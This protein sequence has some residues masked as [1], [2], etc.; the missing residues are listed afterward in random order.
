MEYMFTPWRRKYVVDGVAEEGCVFCRLA[1]DESARDRLL[2]TEHWYLCLNAYPYC[3]GHLMLVSKNHLRWLSEL[4]SAALA[5]MAPLL[6]RAEAALRQAY[7]PE[8]MNM[9]INFA[10]AGGAGVPG[11]LHIHLLPRWAGD[12][13]FMTSVAQTRILPESLEQS[14]DRIEKALAG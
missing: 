6:A 4:S 10:D 8:G 12:T 11:H 2:E 1:A 13:N 7:D 14:F 3:N 9:G 5:E